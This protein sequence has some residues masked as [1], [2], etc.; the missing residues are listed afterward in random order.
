[1]HVPVRV[2]RPQLH[3][4]ASS[5]LPTKHGEFTAHVFLDQGAEGGADKEHVALVFGDI[6]GAQAI[7][8]RVHSECMTSEVFGSLKCDCK[9]QLEYALAAVARA[10]RGAVIYLR[11][12]GRGIG[13]TN[14]IRAYGLQAQGHD[15]VD[16]NRLLGLPDDARKYDI[17]ADILE[18]FGV[19]SIHLLTNN[20]EKVDAL[21]G[22]GVE[23]IGRLPVIIEP[24][25]YSAGYLDTKR[26]RMAH[27]LPRLATAA[28]D[29][30]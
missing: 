25:P 6:D 4:V 29:A 12:E 19:K 9:E 18:F 17:A 11:Q 27:K 2:I 21:R 10:G 8:V 22:L 13:L 28:G 3:W 14:K 16:A 15:T 26:R 20:P 7:P 23:V 24:N 30:E 1:M 5:P